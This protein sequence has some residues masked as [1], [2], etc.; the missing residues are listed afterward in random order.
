[1]LKHL[2]IYNQHKDKQLAIRS[3][4]TLTLDSI[5]L[6]IIH[7]QLVCQLTTFLMVCKYDWSSNK[8]FL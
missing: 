4:Y 5:Q 6:T 3:F 1:M 8:P 7:K 2:I